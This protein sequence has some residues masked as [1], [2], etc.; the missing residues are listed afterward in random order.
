VPKD[1][2]AMTSRPA[3]AGPI[4]EEVVG[5]IV[6][7]I[8]L[9]QKSRLNKDTPVVL[10]GYDYLQPRPA[11]A[12]AA[13][14]GLPVSGPWIYP[15]LLAAGKT[16][17]QMRLIAKDVIDT[18][19]D[20]LDKQVK[21]LPNVYLLDTRRTLKLAEPRTDRASNDWMD[22]IHAL[23]EGWAKLAAK[24]WNPILAKILA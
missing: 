7:W 8:G 4:F 13:V 6:Q 9:R 18:L 17:E 3:R 24:A 16:D 19:N 20:W 15:T 2:K 10:H 5:Y 1:L 12:R 23:P 14:N 11:P 21:P 22:E